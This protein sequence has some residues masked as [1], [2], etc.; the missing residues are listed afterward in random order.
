MRTL[1]LEQYLK[2]GNVAFYSCGNV[3]YDFIN[4][5]R[6]GRTKVFVSDRVNSA[7]KNG[8]L[9]YGSLSEI[10]DEHADVYFLDKEAVKVLLVDFPPSAKYVLVR[11]RPCMS[12]LVGLLGLLRRLWIGLV[13]VEGIVALSA[14]TRTERWLVLRH[15]RIVTL[16]T[17]L[18]LSKEIGIQGFLD[19]LAR[20][21]VRYVV[22]RFYDKLPALNR[23][24][25]DLDLLVA[26]EDE[27]KVKEFLLGHPGPVGVDVW[28]PSRT[29]HNSIT[30]YPPPLARKILDSAVV[31]P[32]GSRIP[33]PRESFLAFAYHAV[34]HKGLFAGLPTALSGLQTN[35]HPENNYTEELVRL[36][37]KLDIA[38]DPTMESVD[39]YLAQE[40]WQPKL[41]T[42]AKIA[43]R[44]K[45]VR[46]RYFDVT[47]SPEVGLSVFIFKRKALKL[48]IQDEM[49]AALQAQEGFLTLK[50]KIF[51][52]QDVA[53]VAEHLRGG[54]WSAGSDQEGDFL[55]A[56]A[57]V[58]IDTHI[59]GS[60]KFAAFHEAPMA[61]IQGLKKQLRKKFDPE[62]GSFVHSTDTT[63][64]AWEYIRWCFSAE[65]AEEL[66]QEIVQVEKN[67]KLTWTEWFRLST[68]LLS[69]ST[70]NTLARIKK[71]FVSYLMK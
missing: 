9:R 32:A 46:R 25:G 33:A 28:T 39:A 27:Y 11:L 2:E 6:R 42:L 55:P 3:S 70:R 65:E 16:H 63:R 22:L 40:G 60:M 41:D 43:P 61:R 58:A 53:R 38:I 68:F 15:N 51:N 47:H 34:Y 8:A 66:R 21:K 24:G 71:G 57:V 45:W 29:S 37:K 50:I 36:A 56:M 48:G 49:L 59:A 17:R 5:E 31:G 26:D 20:E 4:Q 67:S 7:D 69:Y 1:P 54:V 62:K 12:W 10:R 23:Q 18:S 30:Y 44:N 35:P 14:G 52:E 64:E 13:V 19:Y